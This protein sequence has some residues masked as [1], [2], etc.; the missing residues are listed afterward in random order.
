M[1]DAD[2]PPTIR[3]ISAVLPGWRTAQPSLRVL[4]V[5]HSATAAT[6]L[7][8]LIPL[9]QDPRIQLFCTHTSD[10]M[11]PYG[12]DSFIQANEIH[13]L[14]W[15]QATALEFQVAI[16]AGLGDNLHEIKCPIL[17]VPHGNGY[18]KRWTGDRRPATGDRRPVFG[19]SEETL[20]HAGRLVPAAIGLSHDEQF[21]RLAE[22]CAEALPVAFL[23]GDPCHDRMIA[24]LPR[25]LNYR[26]AFGLRPGQRLI[27]VA[28]TWRED[29]LFGVDPLFTSRTLRSLPFDGYRVALVLHPNVWA[30]HSAFQIRAWL[31]ES[32]R[33]GLIL[34][35]PEEGWRAA[36]VAAD[37]VLSDHGSVSVYAAAA[38][39]PVLL[40]QSGRGMIDPRSGLGRLF[41]VAAHLDPHTALEPQLRRAEELRDRTHATAAAMV[42]SA[43]GRSLRL[44]RE[45]LY[46]MM[47]ESPP[48]AEP[49]VLA[50]DAPAVDGTTPA[51]LWTSV[52][53]TGPREF[54]VERWPAAVT[55]AGPGV[56]IVAD[57]ELDHRLA[58]TADVIW[59][60]REAL[61]ADEPTWSASVF[62]HRPGLTLTLV[63]DGRHAVLRSRD[64]RGVKVS[65][66]DSGAA[67]P[68]FAVLAERCVSGTRDLAALS[69]LTLCFGGEQTVSAVFSA[70]SL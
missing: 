4:L 6:R 17:R 24:S 20:K 42:S 50:V 3:R 39:R 28:S 35:P 9:F 19:L 34:L 13:Q 63:R 60:T 7:G 29:S 58:G 5:I 40:D 55:G 27:T 32:L 66:T 67:E 57:H 46:A 45:R 26:H 41:D 61:P 59:T 15:E 69:P 56:L 51:S 1:T 38:G 54:S 36:V 8:D 22:G 48:G 2:L 68:V 49:P 65:L 37:W 33:A 47:D 43:P 44:I 53:R 52:K 21:E 14:S 23:A 10:A 30:S 18:N 64:G 62:E 16:T 11:F 25:R 31:D 70:I 12:I